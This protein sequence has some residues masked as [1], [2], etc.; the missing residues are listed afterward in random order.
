MQRQRDSRR[1]NVQHREMIY[2]VRTAE[3]TRERPR[4]EREQ[5]LPQVRPFDCF[6]RTSPL[7]FFAGILQARI[8][9]SEICGKRGIAECQ[10]QRGATPAPDGLVAHAS[11]GSGCSAITV[12]PRA[13]RD[14][15]Y[16]IM[17]TC[18]VWLSVNGG[19]STWTGWAACSAT[20]GRGFQKRTRSCT[21]PTPLNG[22]TFCDGQNIQKSACTSTCPGNTP[23]WRDSV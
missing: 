11:A 12:V 4:R 20:C 2:G 14:R 8:S 15:G 3:R 5:A 19:W 1:T 18:V 6:W 23:W 21:N 7:A 9:V 10:R 13:C 22:G 16:V 17:V